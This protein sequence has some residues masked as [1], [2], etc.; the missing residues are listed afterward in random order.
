MKEGDAGFLGVFLLVFAALGA[1]IYY[2]NVI[3]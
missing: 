3:L 2:I 1:F